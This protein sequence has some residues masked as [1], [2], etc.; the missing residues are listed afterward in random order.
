MAGFTRNVP[1]GP[2]AR[3]AFQ[4]QPAIQGA[5]AEDQSSVY[6]G[7]Y[8]EM[9]MPAT[10]F[11]T[12][13]ARLSSNE[14]RPD[15]RNSFSNASIVDRH[16]RRKGIHSTGGRQLRKTPTPQ[17]NDPVFSSEF[18]KHLIGPHVNYTINT[19]W[20]IAYPAATISWGTMRNLALSERTPQLP[21]RTTGGPGPTQMASAPRFKSVQQ[22]PRYSTMPSF[23]PTDPQQ[24]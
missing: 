7:F 12:S 14:V 9:P 19:G 6:T 2:P 13:T 5:S 8:G 10:T 21:T 22:I 1:S 16:N 18:N 3:T 20:Y 15:V 23:Y 24:G 17:Y 11:T 4:R